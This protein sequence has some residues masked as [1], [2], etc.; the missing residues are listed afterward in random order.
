MTR[1][2]LLSLPNETSLFWTSTGSVMSFIV[3]NS[4]GT[5][6]GMDGYV[7]IGTS[8]KENQGAGVCGV[9]SMPQIVMNP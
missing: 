9:L 7:L 3:K 1:I 4:W 5:S 6:W 2:E 8:Q